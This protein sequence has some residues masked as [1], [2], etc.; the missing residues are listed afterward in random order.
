MVQKNEI[1]NFCVEKGLLVD[2]DML[3]IFSETSDFDSI[4][5]V[6]EKI[7]N[8]TNQR[9]I[10]KDLFNKNKEK[11]KRVFSNL[12]ENKQKNLEKLQIKLGLSIEISREI[13]ESLN[14]DF[15]NEDNYDSFVSVSPLSKQLEKKLEVSDFTN[16]YKNRFVE[17]RNILQDH[18][19]LDS[20]VSIDK[21]SGNRQG[22][23]TIGIVLDKRKTKNGN[24]LLEVEDL[25]GRIRILI[26]KDKE[27]LFEKADNVCLDSVLGFKGSG[28]SEILFVND[29]V[30]PESLLPE[31]KN[32]KKQEYALFIG[33]LHFGSKMFLKKGFNNFI[34][35]LNGN[36]P[37]TE[38]EVKKIKYLFIV[39]DIITGVGNYPNQEKDLEI[40]DLEEQ[41]I[42]LAELLGKIKKDIKIII[43]PGNHDCVRIMEPQ[44]VLDKKFAWPLFEMENVI[45]TENPSYVN[46]G[47]YEGFSG[48]DILTYHGFSFPYYA[49]NIPDLI[50]KD[51]M[52]SPEEIMKY[53]LKQ[54][55]LA[56]AHGSTQY[57]PLEND[58]LLIRKVPDILVSGHTHKCNISSYNNI[59]IISVSCWEAMTSYQEK[60][61]NKPDHCKVPMLDLKTRNIKILDFEDIEETKKLNK[62]R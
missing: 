27:E 13:D 14:N 44:P 48:I 55:H 53:L 46:I 1:L 24:L 62:L 26:N 35:Y 7:K 36:I 4:K 52:N 15:E 42:Q 21:I 6:I 49:N 2:K 38:E 8:Q 33:D 16:Y 45:L 41:F 43:S 17:M 9:F 30:F 56:P 39:G 54:R 19:E 31:K 32:S 12:P 60:M 5:F 47:S 59:S 50:S 51:A 18:S 28:N 25:T 23:S 61:G 11:F 3:E 10:N 40:N 20:L 58:G 34:N 37:G 57:Y 22:I 29:I